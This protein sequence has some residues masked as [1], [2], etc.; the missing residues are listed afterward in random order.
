MANPTT[1]AYSDGT[2][3]A[4]GQIITDQVALIADTYYP[5]M[6][7]EYDATTAD[8]YQAFSSGTYAGV[9]NGPERT[10]SSAGVGSVILWG[11]VYEGSIVD[12]SGAALTIT[13]DIRAALAAAGIYVK[14][15]A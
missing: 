12:A 8:A 1:Q 3:V 10:L 2:G 4:A 14:R 6:L 13:N 7:L 9:Y 11:E 5:G 15:K